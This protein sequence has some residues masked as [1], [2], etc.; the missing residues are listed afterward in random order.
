MPDDAI[1][2]TLKTGLYR[3]SSAGGVGVPFIGLDAQRND[4]SLK[5][6]FPVGANQMIYRAELPSGGYAPGYLVSYDGTRLLAQPFDASRLELGGQPIEIG[7]DVEHNPSHRAN[8]SASASVLAYFPEAPQV[9]TSI[10]RFGHQFGKLG[11]PG[12]DTLAALARDGTNRVAL[13]R[14]DPRSTENEQIVIVDDRGVEMPLTHNAKTGAPVWSPDG[15]WIAYRRRVPGS[16]TL[17]Y[18]FR[19]ASPSGVGPD[20][21]IARFEGEALPLDWSAD[22]KFLIYTYNGDV[23][24]ISVAD[25]KEDQLTRSGHAHKTARLSNDGRWLAYTLIDKD[26][27][28]VW[29][30]PFPDG[31]TATP[32]PGNGYDPGWSPDGRELYYMTDDGSLM[33]VPMSVSAGTLPVFGTP[34]ALFHISPTS[35]SLNLHVFTVAPDGKFVVRETSPSSSRINVIVNWTSRLKQ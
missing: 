29:V 35:A 31:T 24:K 10:D 16:A 9:L 18:E 11:E 21:L 2:F 19:R 26:G 8:F 13:Q 33:A 7:P 15:R 30:K 17:A 27:R 22:G 6:P 4:H 20:R 28:A 3:V 1:V 14:T 25:G 34:V 5:S 23:W 32:V 12:R